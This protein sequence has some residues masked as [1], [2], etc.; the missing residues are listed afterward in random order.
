MVSRAISGRSG[1]YFIGSF[2][3]GPLVDKLEKYCDLMIAICLNGAAIATVIAPYSPDVSILGFLLILG[4][5]F[6]GII[7]IGWCIILFLINPHFWERGVYK[8]RIQIPQQF[9]YIY[10][11]E[12]C[13][14]DLK[15][16]Y[17]FV[18]L[19]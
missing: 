15:Y 16:I 14:L 18:C 11:V 7:N 4:G 8:T 9:V 19:F 3:G 1:G 5:T 6:E 2:L 10:N 13:F 17:L 12:D